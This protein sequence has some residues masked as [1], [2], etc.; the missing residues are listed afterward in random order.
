MNTTII[1]NEVRM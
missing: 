1:I